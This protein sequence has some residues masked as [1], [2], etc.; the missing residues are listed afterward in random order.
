MVVKLAYFWKQEV[1]EY[2]A[3]VLASYGNFKLVV[4]NNIMPGSEQHCIN[5][6]QWVSYFQDEMLYHICLGVNIVK[7]PEKCT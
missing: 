3:R 7:T 2:T 5:F 1:S 6:M 4:E